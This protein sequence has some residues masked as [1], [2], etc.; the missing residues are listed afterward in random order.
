[1]ATDY[2]DT[3]AQDGKLTPATEAELA[4]W[5]ASGRKSILVS[6]RP[7]YD[8]RPSELDRRGEHA[9]PLVPHAD[10]H[11]DLIVAENGGVLWDPKRDVVIDLCRRVQPELIDS[12]VRAGV[13]EDMLWAG[14]TVVASKIQHLDRIRAGIAGFDV[15]ISL[16][17]ESVM[18]LPKGVDKASG[19]AAACERLGTSTERTV[20]FGDAEN[21][22]TFLEACGLGVAVANAE[23]SVKRIATCI[24]DGERGAGVCQVLALLTRS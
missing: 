12:L 3:L 16:N 8:L 23:E 19:L 13:P 7:L 11:F 15:E 5:R 20:G 21:D 9:P 24:A 14:R 22:L 1:M 2:D 6:G 4:R 10:R 17:R 18:L